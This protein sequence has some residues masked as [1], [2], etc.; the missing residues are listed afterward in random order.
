M[1]KSGLWPMIAILLIAAFLR[2]HRLDAVP[3]GLTHDEAD[4]G[5]FA[6]AVY[7]GTR[8]QVKAPYGY[9]YQPFT[10]YSAAAFMALFGPSD[11][12]LRVHSAFFGLALVLFTY[13]WA[14]RAFGLAVGLGGA[15]LLALSFWTVCDS[16]FALN[17]A[18]APAL[19]AAAAYFLWRA[20]DDRRPERWAWW[21]FA[22]LLAAS[23]Y[24]YE[25]AV[26][27]AASYVMLLFYLAL[28]HPCCCRR[29]CTWFVAMLFIVALLTA[30]HLLDPASWGRT[31][32]LSGPLRAALRGDWRSL[33]G[34]IVSTLGTF[35]ISG[36]S[37]VTYNLPGRPIFD[38]VV[39]LFF[40]GGIAL[41][42]WRWREPAYAFTLMWALAGIAPSL[43]LGE[44]TSTLHSKAAETPLFVL[45]ALG[46]VEAGRLIHRRFGP[47][48]AHT[49]AI[50]CT[51]WL[52][53]VGLYTGYDYFIRWGQS[54]ETRAAYFHNLV[55]IVDYLNE[56]DY[57]GVVALSSPFPDLP[58]DP[59]IAEM[60]LRRDDLDL[61]WF[62]ARRTLVIPADSTTSSLLILPSST[63]LAPVIAD[64][65]P[66][67]RLLERVHL[68]PDDS[69][70]HF[71]VL[72]WKPQEALAQLLPDGTAITVTLG[73]PPYTAALPVNF[74]G[75]VE[76]IAYELLTPQVP[77][78]GTMALLTFWR[79]RNPDALGPVPPHA[80]GRAAAIFV[81]ALDDGGNV[82]GQEDRLDAP[83]W[84]WHPGDAFVQLHCF[85]VDAD[86]PPGLYRLEVG[87]Y[88]R[89]DLTRLP[90]I[91][92]GVEVD[93]RILLPPVEVV[94]Q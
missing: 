35:S 78:G 40:Y 50:L 23:F 36:D 39:S 19:L 32:T 13:L 26:A 3:P 84:N 1:S 73:A 51:L 93:D 80:Y 68:R 30:P 91:V 52:G 48:W 83:A 12:A 81:H 20:L 55:A 42:L 61:R 92:N 4:T 29:H 11:R 71:D 44:W 10:M 47:R 72:E 59:F 21:P 94:G 16:R 22:L 88:T 43:A 27:A 49:F 56:T 87:I 24:V 76:L 82:V 6:A 46:A 34:N 75:A 15:A 57:R 2:L 41:C 45:P 63:P 77:F 67:P 5:Y 74:G 86:T 64:R 58:L 66:A 85:Q 25:A 60:R 31:N 9:A 8:S 90:V 38:P 69:D 79:I 7:R 70:P 54:P 17:S 37:F 53:V 18:P 14:R 62:D 89:E 28:V 65:L 33:L